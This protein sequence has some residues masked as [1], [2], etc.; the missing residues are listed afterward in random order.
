MSTVGL[1]LLVGALMLQG[2]EPSPP[3][4]DP[5]DRILTQL[6]RRGEG[7]Q[8]IKAAVTY[9]EVDQLN[10]SERAKEGQ[11]LFLLTD[12]NPLFFIQFDKTSVDGQLGKREWYLFDGEWLYEANERTRHVTQRQIA[13]PGEKVDLFDIETAP[14]PLPFGQKKD[15]ILQHF[16]VTLQP[17]RKGDPPNTDHLVCTPKPNTRLARNYDKL[18]FYILRDLH[19]PRKVVMTKS[20]G[21]EVVTAEFPDL[22]AASINTRVK[23]SDFKEPR[24]WQKYERV[25]ERLEAPAAKP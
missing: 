24:A 21:Y 4:A 1:T 5:I 13:R 7:V 11:I 18:D 20:K 17:P 8:D 15:K 16:D 22:S 19:L 9:C 10:L 2:S 6:E 3:A 12:A 25:V 23:R 14:F